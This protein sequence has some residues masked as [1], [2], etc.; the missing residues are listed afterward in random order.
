MPELQEFRVT[1]RIDRWRWPVTY[2]PH[3]NWIE[4]HRGLL[5]VAA[6]VTRNHKVL[7][8]AVWDESDTVADRKLDDEA[9]VLDEVKITKVKPSFLHNAERPEDIEKQNRLLLP[10]EET[11]A[12]QPLKVSLCLLYRPST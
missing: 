11:E 4:S 3:N 5:W 12:I 9:N 7:K 1:T 8:Y 6:W 10:G 2:E